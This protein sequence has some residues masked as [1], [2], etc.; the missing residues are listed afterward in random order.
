MRPKFNTNP[1]I[2]HMFIFILAF[3]LLIDSRI[4]EVNDK[5]LFVSTELWRFSC[6][7]NDTDEHVQNEWQWKC[8]SRDYVGQ[9][10]FVCVCDSSFCDK[11]EPIGLA[12]DD[13]ETLVYYLTDRSKNRLTRMSTK[14]RRTLSR[15]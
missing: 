11:P 13:S 1:K 14:F 2:F 10:S 8:R 7:E 15:I 9:S 5:G 3:V 6:L 4:E 12:P